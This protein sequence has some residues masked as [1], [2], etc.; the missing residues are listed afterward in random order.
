ML[1][2]RPRLPAAAFAAVVLT[3]TFAGGRQ[4]I[5]FDCAKAK[6]PSEKAICA[7]PAA[8]AADEAMTKAFEAFRAGADPATRAKIL[9]SQVRWLS[10]RD[11]DC[12]DKSGA[13]LS[14][15]LAR[16]SD[17]RRRYLTGAPA[18]GPGAPDPIAPFLRVEKGGKG[19]ADVDMELLK[20]VKP[21]NG[22]ERAFNAGVDKFM[23]D[24][25]EPDDPKT[26]T[27]AFA[28]SMSL[29][30]ASTRLVSARAQGYADA[31]GAHPNSYIAHV[32]I[33]LSLGRE[34]KFAD[35]ADGAGAEKI[36]ALCYDQV[37]A[38]K[39]DRLGDDAP[40]TADDLKDLAKTVK[41]S[42]A[43]LSGWGFGADEAT[44]DYNPYSVGAY[45]E[46]FYDCKLPY[47]R[48][49]PLIKSSFPLP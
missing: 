48:L 6:S 33:D 17:D 12:S 9:E 10:T 32:N 16:E 43:D 8:R 29:E 24:I 46:G 34:L 19:R 28:T 21:A 40:M 27:Y 44:V 22:A 30:Y 37:K 3:A 1:Y 39:K 45:V 35:L 15:C 26:D 11:G 7:D 23:E 18:T 25:T 47:E 2:C 42:T 41:E 5:A 4:A 13:E 20:F 49:R 14:A 36:I 38:A 31:G